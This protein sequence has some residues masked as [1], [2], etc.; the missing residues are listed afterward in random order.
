MALGYALWLLLIHQV[1]PN[2]Q[3]LVGAAAQLHYILGTNPMNKCYFTGAGGNPVHHPHHR[4]SWVLGQALPGMVGEGANGMNVGGDRLLQA[5]FDSH[6]PPA[7][8]YADHKDSW[9][10][11]E[12]TIYGNAMFV[13]VAA[14]FTRTDTH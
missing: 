4:P 5:M 8:C 2:P 3:Q 14:W 1:S 6:I 7:R 10:T 11:N 13:A 12:P 9:A